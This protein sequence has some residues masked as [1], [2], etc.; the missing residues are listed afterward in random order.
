[1]HKELAMFTALI[2]WIKR[3]YAP[4][5]EMLQGVPPIAAHRIFLPF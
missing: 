5:F 3:A 1:M 2:R 4:M